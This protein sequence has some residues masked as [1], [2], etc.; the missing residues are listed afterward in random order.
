MIYHVQQYGIDHWETFDEPGAR[1]ASRNETDALEE[2]TAI[3]MDK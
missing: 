2:A 3:I 1:H